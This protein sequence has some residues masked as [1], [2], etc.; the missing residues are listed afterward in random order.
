MTSATTELERALKIFSRFFDLIHQPITIINK[1]GKFIY[2]NHESAEI[3]NYGNQNALGKRVLEVYNHLKE[4]NSTMVK[5]CQIGRPCFAC[6][7][8]AMG[9]IHTIPHAKSSTRRPAVL[10]RSTRMCA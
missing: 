4:E 10:S 2:Y 9:N 8:L 3:D 5:S 6:Q 7:T 1:E